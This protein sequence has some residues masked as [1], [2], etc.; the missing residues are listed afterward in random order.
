MR[1]MNAGNRGVILLI[2]LIFVCLLGI[3][4]L[5]YSRGAFQSARV[6]Y[7]SEQEEVAKRIVEAAVDEAFFVLD[8]SSEDPAAPSTRWLVDRSQVAPSTLGLGD[9]PQTKGIVDNLQQDGVI[10]VSALEVQIAKRTEDFRNSR[11]PSGTPSYY[12][13]EGHGTVVLRGT[14][15]VSRSGQPFLG[16]TL[17][18]HHDYKVACLVSKRQTEAARAAAQCRSL[19]YA[20]YVREGLNEFK[21]TRGKML[22]NSSL[23]FQVKPK[24]KGLIYFGGTEGSSEFVF[25]NIDPGQPDQLPPSE[26]AQ[27]TL[28]RTETDQIGDKVVAT[29][30]DFSSYAQQI[31]D[32][33]AE[34]GVVLKSTYIPLDPNAV[35]KPKYAQDGLF[36]DPA[37]PANANENIEPGARL[38]EP[39][40]D[41]KL[42]IEGRVRKRFIDL[43]EADQ[44]KKFLDLVKQ[45]M[46]SLKVP[47]FFIS[48]QPDDYKRRCAKAGEA[49]DNIILGIEE[50]MATL[51][52]APLS[53]SV[54]LI[55]DEL[56]Y[57]SNAKAD[58]N[59]QTRARTL[60]ESY[61]P[62]DYK[63]L[64]S[65][66]VA[67]K[68][69]LSSIG[70]LDGNTLALQGAVHV[71]S[72]FVLGDGG[73]MTVKGQGVIS[74]NGD[75]V[76][77]A[78]ITCEP[79]AILVLATKGKLF[80]QTK[81]KIEAGIMANSIIIT[82]GGALNL[83]GSLWVNRLGSDGWP[84]GP[85]VIEYDPDRFYRADGDVYSVNV[86]PRCTFIRMMAVD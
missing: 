51:P 54:S 68:A 75:I 60:P 58:R 45:Y 3:W 83:H 81:D 86:S 20:L 16:F 19:D 26:T 70:F 78:G 43:V 18:K 31:K 7:R 67:A 33:I 80:V 69:D 8:E 79:G 12:G 72:G 61:L 85:H 48:M 82:G 47:D 64:R 77:K 4:V 34:L 49:V 63:N 37:N 56:P 9:L 46:P 59:T 28:T 38:L 15:R 36:E 52:A 50:V 71:R 27:R 65:F 35:D 29:N 57:G 24:G 32:K 17:E 39:G 14:I 23:K 6:A 21:T 76:I 74:T 5:T 1:T 44:L 11:S 25:L 13:N 22:N 62:F 66:S 53:T 55:D 42:I 84:A 30:P 73:P 40:D 41:P 2:V 10:Q